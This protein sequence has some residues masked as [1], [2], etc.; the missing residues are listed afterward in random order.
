MFYSL[1]CP[2]LLPLSHLLR[3]TLSAGSILGPCTWFEDQSHLFM[4]ITGEFSG[5]KRQPVLQH[6]KSSSWL[7][8][9]RLGVPRKSKSIS[10]ERT[11]TCCLSHSLWWSPYFQLHQQGLIKHR[12]LHPLGCICIIHGNRTEEFSMP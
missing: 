9:N 8:G 3:D 11:C 10:S 4:C 2:N 1:H 5:V 7:A 12:S 6:S